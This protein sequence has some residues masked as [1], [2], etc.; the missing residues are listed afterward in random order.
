MLKSRRAKALLQERIM[1]SYYYPLGARAA[2]S[3]GWAVVA[4]LALLAACMVFAQAAL[5]R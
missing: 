5:P 3:I 4:A 2:R 1:R